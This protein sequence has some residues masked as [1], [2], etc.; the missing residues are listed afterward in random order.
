MQVLFDE[1]AL[2]RDGAAVRLTQ[3]LGELKIPPTVQGI[4][5]ARIDRAAG[6]CQG[7]TAD[8][9]GHRARISTVVDSWGGHEIG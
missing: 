9:G 6:R 5:A 3:A 7:A 2:L 1:G 8:V 4:L